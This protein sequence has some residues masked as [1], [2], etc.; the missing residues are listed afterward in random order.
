MPDNELKNAYNVFK[1]T[2]SDEFVFNALKKGYSD[3][4]KI[5]KK[6]PENFV[7]KVFNKDEKNI[8]KTTPTFS[9]EQVEENIKESP[10][11]VRTVMRPEV[12]SVEKKSHLFSNLKY[13]VSLDKLEVKK[14]LNNSETFSLV[15]D[16]FDKAVGVSYKKQIGNAVWKS[17]LEY[18][19]F[20]EGFKLTT[21]YQIKGQ[22]YS[23]KL[24]I[25]EENYGVN[26]GGKYKIDKNSQ[27]KFSGSLFKTDSAVKIEYQ[28][29]DRQ[30]NKTSIGLY[31][32]TKYKEIGV[33]FRM[34]TF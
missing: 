31:G 16:N 33:T 18:E 9:S 25:D 26:L 6:I 13:D 1:D 24:Y 7:E 17:G 20:D 5:L 11:A 22:A 28:T 2:N 10:N 4:I 19:P 34:T 23:A 30:G 12:E 32:S 8:T 3:E 27:V 21:N 15:S 14:R 29:E